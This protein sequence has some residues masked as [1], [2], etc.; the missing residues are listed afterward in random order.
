MEIKQLFKKDIGS[1]LELESIHAP[2]LPHYFPYDRKELDDYLMGGAFEAF[3]MVDGDKLIAWSAY[4]KTDDNSYEI[5]SLVLDKN[6]RK[7]GLGK[8]LLLY[9]IEQI[10]SKYKNVRIHLSVSPINLPALLLYLNSGFIIYDY[11]KDYFGPGVDRVLLQL[12]P[13]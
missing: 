6:Y 7:K 3:G 9:V 2:K 12:P 10:R 11:K 13:S 1:I 5:C 4:K 8:K